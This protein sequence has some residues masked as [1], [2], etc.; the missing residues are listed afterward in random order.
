M[1]DPFNEE[2]LEMKIK[3]LLKNNHT[4]QARYTYQWFCDN[5]EKGFGDAFPRSFDQISATGE[6]NR[7]KNSIV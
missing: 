1:G 5:Y 2:A 6:M 7:E 4:N 3:T